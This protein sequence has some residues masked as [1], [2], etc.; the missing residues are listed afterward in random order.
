MQ[1]HSLLRPAIL[2]ARPRLEVADIFRNHGEHYRNTYPLNTEQLKAMTDIQRC[3]T[4]ALGGHVD[5]CDHG[6][7]FMRISYNSCRNRNCPKCQALQSARWLEKQTE[8][9]LPCRYFHVI[10]TFPHQLNPLILHNKEVLYNILVSI[11]SPFP[12]RIGTKMEKTS[13]THRLHCCA[14]YLEPGPC[15]FI[16]TF[17][18]SSPQAAWIGLTQDGSS[19]ATSSWSRSKPYLPKSEASF[20]TI[21]REPMVR[22]R[23]PFPEALSPWQIRRH[24][25][26]W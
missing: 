3:R 25:A 2:A 18:W 4:A 17:T 1:A 12:A 15:A 16:H 26:L 19:H 22:V 8:R 10:V 7:G 13:S 11:S 14:S 6:C 21:S 24:S 5:V 23:S 9:I 20:S